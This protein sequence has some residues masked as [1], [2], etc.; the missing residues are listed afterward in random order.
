[1]PCVIG[2]L[3]SLSYSPNREYGANEKIDNFDY[4]LNFMMLAT[5]VIQMDGQLSNNELSYFKQKI[6]KHYGL[7]FSNAYSGLIRQ[8]LRIRISL[9]DIIPPIAKHTPLKEKENG[10]RFLFD[11]AYFDGRINSEETAFLELVRKSLNIGQPFYN[12]L[13]RE[14]EQNNRSGKRPSKLS[15]SNS[16]LILNL[17]SS[18]SN[19]EV[20]KAYYKLAMKYHPDKFESEGEIEVEKAKIKF[21][22]ILDAFEQIKKERGLA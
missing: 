13:R 12:G 9:N 4:R 2:L 15:N 18:A 10:L 20:K 17:K 19:E 5:R 22:E 3:I 8:Y 1:M 14:F 6:E 16:Y 7:P 11:I 21:Q